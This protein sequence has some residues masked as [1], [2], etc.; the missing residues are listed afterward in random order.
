M[1]VSRGQSHAEIGVGRSAFV[2]PIGLGRTMYILSETT[3]RL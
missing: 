1:K 2:L 3:G